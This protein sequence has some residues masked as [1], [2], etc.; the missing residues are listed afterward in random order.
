[1]SLLDPC[2]WHQLP[3]FVLSPPLFH[4]AARSAP[5]K[6]IVS[7]GKFAS[8][9]VSGSTCLNLSIAT[10]MISRRIAEAGRYM[11]SLWEVMSNFQV[12]STTV[13]N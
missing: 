9:G 11:R 3:F 5:V 7:R 13:K 6:R 1:M 4:S 10:A 8:E 12:D 2:F